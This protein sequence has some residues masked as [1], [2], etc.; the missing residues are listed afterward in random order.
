MQRNDNWEEKKNG[1]E[2]WKIFMSTSSSLLKSQTTM[3]K[4][5]LSLRSNIYL[6][7]NLEYKEE[8]ELRGKLVI[9]KVSRPRDNEEETQRTEKIFIQ[10]EIH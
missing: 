5:K 2:R 10:N 9:T 4:R 7:T 3:C 1:G 8:F 6:S